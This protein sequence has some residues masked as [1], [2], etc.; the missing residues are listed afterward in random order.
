MRLMQKG[1]VLEISRFFSVAMIG[2]I[3]D[4]SLALLLIVIFGFSDIPC[5]DLETWREWVRLLGSVS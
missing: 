1:T 5:T 4:I 3:I 2:L